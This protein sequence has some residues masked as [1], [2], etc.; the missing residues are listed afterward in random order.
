MWGCKKLKPPRNVIREGAKSSVDKQYICF[1][2]HL[3][4]IISLL[5]RI[6]HSTNNLKKLDRGRYDC[7]VDNYFLVRIYITV[8]RIRL[9]KG[10]R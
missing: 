1:D 2:L 6:I 8:C 4:K 9:V 5:F 10:M 7:K 3:K